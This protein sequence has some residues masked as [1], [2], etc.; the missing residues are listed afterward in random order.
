MFAK[1]ARSEPE[2]S[3]GKD[4]FVAMVED[5]PVAVMTCDLKDF[6]INYVNKATIDGLKSIKDA[7]PID[8]D[9]IMGQS[10]DIFHKNPA[11][12]RKLLADPSN[13]PFKTHITVKVPARIEQTLQT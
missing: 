8:P 3:L 11:H 7:L 13:L 2:P 6:R 12:Q 5:M 9:D 10:I 1:F 4:L